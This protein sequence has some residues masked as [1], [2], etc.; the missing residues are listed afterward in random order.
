MLAGAYTWDSDLD[1][2]DFKVDAE[3]NFILEI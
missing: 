1:I 3:L 2:S